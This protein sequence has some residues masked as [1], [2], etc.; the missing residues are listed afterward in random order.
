[1]L[2]TSLR[3]IV[4]AVAAWGLA[5]SCAFG[6]T[7]LLKES[8]PNGVDS[9]Q[10]K[11][12]DGDTLQ[13]V[14]TSFWQSREHI[15]AAVFE[16]DVRDFDLGVHAQP[17]K[18]KQTERAN[19]SVWYDSP[20]KR[21]RLDYEVDGVDG[22]AGQI[23]RTPEFVLSGNGS[24]LKQSP[25]DEPYGW[26]PI[27]C[28]DVRVIGAVNEFEFGQTYPDEGLD[29]IRKMLTGDVQPVVEQIDDGRFTA[30]WEY[31]KPINGDRVS[32][33]FRR[34]WIDEG[35]DYSPVRVEYIRWVDDKVPP[36]P[37]NIC[38][39]E[40]EDVDGSWV[41]AKCV[42]NEWGEGASKRSDAV[43]ESVWTFHWHSVNEEIRDGVF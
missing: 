12:V 2:S 5:G 20:G 38:T 29:R 14:M 23:I 9:S 35:L 33:A 15:K 1:M 43:K 26:H 27:P 3:L 42:F 4:V 24:V 25:P 36:R 30:T 19:Y 11:L 31:E 37:Q 8:L 7:M 41:P 6:Q 18:P 40:Y 16:V 21:V 13:T 28:F 10:V 22:L 39:V 17:V 34:I 32:H